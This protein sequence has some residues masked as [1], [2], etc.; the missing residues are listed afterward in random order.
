MNHDREGVL[1]VNKAAGSTSFSLVNLLRKLTRIR[2]IGHA[3]TLDPFAT[4]V[5]V[6][7][8]GRK[9][10]KRSNE[11]MHFDKE[12]QATL[13]LGIQTDTYDIDGQVMCRSDIVPT[14]LQI[15]TAIQAFQ[16]IFLQTPPMFSA[17]KVQGKKLYDLARQGITVERKAVPVT[18][19]VSILDYTYPH[20]TIHVAC[21]KGTYIRSIAHDL[22]LHLECGAHL[23]TLVRLKVGP[24]ALDECISEETLRSN[25]LNELNVRQQ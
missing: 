12:Y 21:S 14:R 19:K 16:G 8:I 20:L 10:T 25:V 7:L 22:G 17:K 6:M 1:L 18:A 11:F 15:D 5:M 4:G 24:Y 3:G 9:F 13:H 2:T 23:A